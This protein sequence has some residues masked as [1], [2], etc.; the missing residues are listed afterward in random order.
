VF[1]RHVWFF[2]LI[3]GLMLSACSPF[4]NSPAS[5]IQAAE[6]LPTQEDNTTAAPSRPAGP[7][8][9]ALPDS[10][11]VAQVPDSACP[12]TMPQNPPFTPPA[13]SP[14]SPPGEHFW[15]GSD[16]LWTALPQNGV[17]AALPHNPEGYT[18]KLIWGRKGYS[19]TEQPEPQLIVTGR[20]MDAP[21]PP[22][23][24]D[25][26][27]NVLADDIG[28]AMMVGVDFPTLGCWEISGRYQ[29]AELSFVVWVLP[30]QVFPLP[31]RTSDLEALKLIAIGEQA[32]QIAQQEAPNLVL[33]QVD[34]DLSVTDFQFVDR[35]LTQVITVV[36]P[37]TDAPVDTWYT[38]VNSIS[39][40]L[41]HSE[42]ALNLPN[43]RTGPT[44]VVQSITAH[45]PGCTLRGIMLYREQGQL[46]WLAFCNTPEGVV[47][48]SLQDRSGVFQPSEAPPAPL[49]AIAT[50][51][52]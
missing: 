4:R 5:S 40:L 9:S 49:P 12:V 11:E 15:Y 35:S 45:W 26:A 8:A 31:E 39:P 44:R 18:Q 7:V 21:A 41:S 14:A 27:T 3:L 48:G 46:T 52:P 25:K 2:L 32:L 24:V 51:V 23:H 29:E 22:L 43:L 42:P 6:P 47:S 30:E 36:I 20:R 16:S 37:Q 28:S 19:S 13:P 50:P 33:R 34:T 10:A 17:W 38:T 1:P